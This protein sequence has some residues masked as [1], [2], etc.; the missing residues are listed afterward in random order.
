[1][2]LQPG[3]HLPEGPIRSY[4]LVALFVPFSI[5]LMGALL[6]PALGGST[7]WLYAALVLLPILAAV[8]VGVLG[9]ARGYPTWALP[10]VGVLL[11]I[12]WFPLKWAA[13]AVIPIVLGVL[14][15]AAVF[16][17]ASRTSAGL[18][19][20]LVG[21][22]W[23]EALGGKLAQQA[24]LDV[25]FLAIAALMVGLL[26]RLSPSLWQRARR[27]WS[28]LSFLL[29]GMSIPYVVGTDSYRG[30]EPYQVASACLL[31]TGAVLFVLV[32]ARWQRLLALVAATLVAHPLLSLGVYRILPGQPFATPDPSFRLWEA[33]GAVLELPVL[34]ALLCLPALLAPWPTG[35]RDD[36]QRGP[37]PQGQA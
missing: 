6:P 28:S 31:G 37:Q 34:V 24:V 17:T 33:L 16:L 27:D 22:F 14:Q 19:G 35:P 21:S 9:L 1:M 29:Y 8:A 30:L 32:P 13:Q 3:I 23:P 18:S 2:K 15:K 12:V 4:L 5:P 20:Q 11:Y 26:L 7:P 36:V 25:A 10:A